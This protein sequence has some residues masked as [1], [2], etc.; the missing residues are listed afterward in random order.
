VREKSITNSATILKGDELRPIVQ[1]HRRK[2]DS[3]IEFCITD[4]C[5]QWSQR[6]HCV[7]EDPAPLQVLQRMEQ[8]NEKKIMKK[9]QVIIWIQATKSSC[10]CCYHIMY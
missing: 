9:L 3:P 8:N 5:T 7:V 4:Q 10:N 2:G 1:F 6:Q